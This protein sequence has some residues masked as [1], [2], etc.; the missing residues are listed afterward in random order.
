MMPN[1]E[2][3]HIRQKAYFAKELAPKVRRVGCLYSRIADKLDFG[4]FP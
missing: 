3:K 2:D 4:H 1:K